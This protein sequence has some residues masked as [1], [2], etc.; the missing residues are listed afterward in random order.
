MPLV[1]NA[2]W[3]DCVAV[4]LQRLRLEGVWRVLPARHGTDAVAGGK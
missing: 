3:T 1:R 4:Q 2:L